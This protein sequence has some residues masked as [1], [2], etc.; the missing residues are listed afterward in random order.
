M[1]RLADDLALIPLFSGLN[2][3]QLRKLAGGF[4]ELGFAP[5]RAVVR[6]G[7]ADGVGFFVV[8]EGTAVVSVGGETVATIGPGDHFGELAMITRQPRTATV[9]AETPLRCLTIRFWD[10]REFAKAN[11]DVSWNLLQHLAGLLVEDRARR[12]QATPDSAG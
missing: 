2:K 12:T 3:R 9:T 10:F 5:G 11:P 1:A 6:E 4:K 8:A 7:H